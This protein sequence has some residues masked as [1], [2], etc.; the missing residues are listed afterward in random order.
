MKYPWRIKKFLTI[1][2]KQMAIKASGRGT[3]LLTLS[4]GIQFDTG[5]I[6]ASPVRTCEILWRKGRYVLVWTSDYLEPAPIKGIIGGIDI[7]EIHPVALCGEHGQGLV[8]SGREIRSI[9][10]LRNKS[11]AWFSRALSRCKE[12]KSSTQETDEGQ[13]VPHQQD[14]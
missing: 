11:L 8:V 6:P 9:K 4:F 7:G 13:V 1:P 2:F 14:G 12:E 10:Q 3:I 5:V